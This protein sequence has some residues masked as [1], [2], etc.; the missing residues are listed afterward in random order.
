MKLIDCKQNMRLWMNCQK[1]N[2]KTIKMIRYFIFSFFIFSNSIAQK[3]D[4]KEI[5]ALTGNPI[6]LTNENKVDKLS[7][8]SFDN[9]TYDCSTVFW[10][11]NNVGNIQQWNL[12][13]NQVIGGLTVLSCNGT[14]IAFCGDNDSL[15]FYSSSFPSTGILKYDLNVGWTTISTTIPL[16]NNGGFLNNQYFFYYDNLSLKDLYHFDGINLSLIEHLNDSESFGLA[17]ISVD[18]LGRAWVFTG[19]TSS[20]IDTLRIYDQ[21]GLVTS[22]PISI[23]GSFCYG[24]FFINDQLYLGVGSNFTYYANSLLPI[25]VNGTSA[26]IGTPIPFQNNAYYDMASCNNQSNFLNTNSNIYE[27]K[28]SIIFPNPSKNFITI[29]NNQN[30]TENFQFT[31]TD[32]TGKILKIGKSKFNEEIS[33]ESLESGNYFI[34]IQTYNG[35]K[36]TEKFIKK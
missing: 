26:T 6:Y 11:I 29:I 33:I 25:I 18:S 1:I 12:I 15:T 9:L 13:A 3:L 5:N 2:E 31:I 30:Q 32:L 22:Y 36:L 16:L 10:T 27:P 14:S 7:T 24:S 19:Q 23:N 4:L 35:K 8:Q 20:S 17:D 34:Q 21:N 28:N